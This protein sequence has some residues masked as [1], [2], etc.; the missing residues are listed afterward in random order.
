ME[1]NS[2][3]QN[4]ADY[5]DPIYE[6]LNGNGI[7]ALA[8]ELMNYDPADDGL[9][10]SDLRT[11]PETPERRKM[12]WHSMRP[13]E[14]ALIRMFEDGEVSIKT[15]SGQTVRYTFAEGE[16]FRVPQAELRRH[17]T[18]VMNRHDAKDGDLVELIHE[19][20]GETLLDADGT[21][22]STIKMLRGAIECEEHEHGTTDDDA[23]TKVKRQGVRCFE[24]APTELILRAISARYE[25]EEPAD[26]Q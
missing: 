3:H 25:R 8:W 6:E 7:N 15:E 1:I 4:D 11:A 16:R 13:V 9:S 18:P 10:W 2:D 21:E 20:V 17:L 12:R 24:F 22:H 23:W 19:I 26:D 5:F 14:R